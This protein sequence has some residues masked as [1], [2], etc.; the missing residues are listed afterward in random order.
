MS[1]TDEEIIN[2][3]Q[4]IREQNNTHWMDIVRLAFRVSPEES[5]VIFKKIKHC[6]Y[7]VNE[8]LKE[9]AEND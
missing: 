8:L 3:V 2:E 1:K 6:D 5:R 4:K 9:L 7:R